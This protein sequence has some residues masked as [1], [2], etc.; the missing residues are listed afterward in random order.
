MFVDDL[1]GTI[2]I[3]LD[4]LPKVLEYENWFSLAPA[5]NFN[6]GGE[7]HVKL[8]YQNAPWMSFEKPRDKLNQSPIPTSPCITSEFEMQTSKSAFHPFSEGREEVQGFE[9]PTQIP[10]DASFLLRGTIV[11][12][13]NL[14]TA[15]GPPNAQCI[16]SCRRKKIST[17]IIQESSQPEWNY[18][19]VFGEHYDLTL[20]DQ[21]T[22]TL[23]DGDSQSRAI[24]NASIP[25]RQV[26]QQ[27][28]MRLSS[29]ISLDHVDDTNH[30]YRQARQRQPH[31]EPRILVALVLDWAPR[32][33]VTLHSA[34][35]LTL[36][37]GTHSSNPYC[38][39]SC[40]IE[41]K[42][43]LIIEKTLNPSWEQTFIFESHSR[44]LQQDD[45]VL[46]EI[47]DSSTPN[48]DDFIGRVEVPIRELKQQEQPNTRWYILKSASGDDAGRVRLTFHIVAPWIDQCLH[49]T[50]TEMLKAN[51]RE[52]R[53]EY[54][55]FVYPKDHY[56]MQENDFREPFN[57]N[58]FHK[59]GQNRQQRG[60]LSQNEHDEGHVHQVFESSYQY[61]EHHGLNQATRVHPK[62]TRED[63]IGNK[64]SGFDQRQNTKHPYEYIQQDIQQGDDF[65]LPTPL[66]P[67]FGNG[68]PAIS[69]FAKPSQPQT[70][71]QFQARH[72]DINWRKLA[73]VDMDELVATV[74]VATL[75]EFVDQLVFCDTQPNND[76]R[77]RRHF[78]DPRF[79]QLFR[80]TQLTAEYLIHSQNDL[81]RR[82]MEL[83]EEIQGMEEETAAAALLLR[84]KVDQVDNLKRELAQKRRTA[85][86]YERVL[87][88]KTAPVPPSLP[89][90][91]V[92]PYACPYCP[93]IFQTLEYLRSHQMRR[94]SELCDPN[95]KT[96]QPVGL[97][98]SDV[99]R[100]VASE[101]SKIASELTQFLNDKYSREFA[102][103]KE[104]LY[105]TILY[106]SFDTMLLFLLSSLWRQWFSF[107]VCFF[108]SFM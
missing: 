24:G 5:K 85:S 91:T 66:L 19:F 83:E 41:K 56:S 80:L 6:H 52:R 30:Q 20:N 81:H 32:L 48:R 37:D 97:T 58:I 68:A 100:V 77:G 7:L 44:L 9:Y 60:Q 75:Q 26:Y 51:T 89:Q 101:T 96:K 62:S 65:S 31:G 42:R 70:K 57:Q 102:R 67:S 108:K 73:R 103:L 35:D 95:I 90:P 38:T 72:G 36:L 46:V 43:S 50:Q 105:H 104:R 39:L 1:L 93:K 18:E 27:P 40:G 107:C 25:L 78:K 55:Q 23:I 87:G 92:V 59:E 21:L 4:S 45:L 13:S 53:E 49:G 16:I 84:D 94:H 14:F 34:Q 79:V 15:Y 76:H 54:N 22:L 61:G 10:D 11:C 86:T 12:A 29:W 28:S 98:E 99:Q 17:P 88:A 3:R 33:Y 71:F 64:H 63:R 47:W 2:Q 8:S 106:V 74:D 82:S 69:P